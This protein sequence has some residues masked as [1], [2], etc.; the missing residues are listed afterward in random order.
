MWQCATHAS[1]DVET[2]R[3]YKSGKPISTI[4]PT[5]ELQFPPALD[6]AFTGVGA[7]ALQIAIGQLLAVA[8]GCTS[9][10]LRA[11]G[12]WIIDLTP[13][14]LVDVAIA[15]LKSADKPVILWTLILLWLSS[16]G[17]AGWAGGHVAAAAALV[18]L[19][20]LGLAA[21]LRRP[22]LPRLR[23]L[24]VA[25][26]AAA[27]GPGAVFLLSPAAALGAAAVML[28]VASAVD[29]V[30]RRSASL[31]RREIV[32]DAGRSDRPSAW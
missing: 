5:M 4:L 25:V 1:R 13:G 15:L 18:L 11:V 3:T 6:D 30:R 12:R 17:L 10:P 21:S 31:L 16:A 14:P 28:L 26:A 8:Y 7:A 2:A 22:E 19:G 29:A 20:A 23:A 27:A 32:P 9:S 24:T